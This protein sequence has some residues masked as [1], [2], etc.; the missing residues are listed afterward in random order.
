MDH[1][2]LE[3]RA[4]L[5][6]ICKKYQKLFHFEEEPLSLTTAIQ[7]DIKVPEGVAS[8]NIR[9]YRLPYPH[10]Q[11]IVE[12]MGKL[13]EN[14]IIRPSESPWNAPLVVA[15]KKPDATGKPQFRICVDFRR[16]NQLTIGDAFPIPRI[17][18]ILDQLGRSRYYTTLDLASEYHQV[19]I[20]PQNCDK[21]ALRHFPQ[22]RDTL[23][24]SGCLSDYVELLARSSG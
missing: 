14:N 22:I 18:E 2:N 6:R 7:H 10:R 3:E 15:P 1:L 5:L 13:E 19:P 11:V 16:L 8:V 23:S 21:T 24:L 17:D 9:P 4:S 12:Q 20:R